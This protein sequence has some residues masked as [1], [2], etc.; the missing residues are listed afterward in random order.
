MTIDNLLACEVVTADGRILRAS[1]SENEDLFWAL[2]GGG[3]N[4][5]VVTS[6]EFAAHPLGPEVAFVQTLYPLEAGPEVFAGYLDFVATAPD[7]VTADIGIWSLPAV[8]EVPAELHGLP[9]VS[10]H[11]L[12]A[13]P[14]DLGEEVIRPLRELAE[15]LDDA[16]SV[17]DYVALQ[18]QSDDL[19]PAGLRYYWKSHYLDKLSP[20]AV[21]E[22]LDWSDA[23]P[24]RRRSSSFG[25]WAVRSVAYRPMRQLSATAAPPSSSRS[26]RRGPGKGRIGRTSA[27]REPSGKTPSDSR[28]AGRTS[29][30]PASSRRAKRSCDG[31]SA[32]VVVGASPLEQL[33]IAQLGPREQRHGADPGEVAKSR[34]EVRL[35]LIEP[36]ERRG[37]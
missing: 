23:G 15:P 16:S 11:A 29:A 6:F 17:L 35:R 26:T 34:V 18:S 33:G 7:E 32:G 5:G 9:F 25:T 14:P 36:T 20:A 21:E 8:E 1:E 31:A 2:R 19:F 13:G 28:R 30:S 3:G 22:I 37:E 27:G 12:Y 24:R 4:F 10:V